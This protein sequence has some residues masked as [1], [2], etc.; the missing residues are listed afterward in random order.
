MEIFALD[1]G[2]KQT[3]L[4]SKKAEYVLPSQILN[5]DDMS[6]QL[7]SFGK[8]R[9]I[10][11]FKVPFDDSTWLWGSDLVT[12][13]RDDYLQD[14]LMHQNRYTNDTFKLLANFALGLLA[15]DYK[16]AGEGILEVT[17]VTGLPTDDYNSSKQLADLTEVL[18]GQHQIEVN[19]KTYTVRVERV[20]IVPQPVGTFYDVLLDKKGYLQDED[21]LEEKVGIVDA[22]GGTI[23]I[24]T[25]LNFELDKRNRR[26]YSTGANDLYEA[27]MSQMD[28]NV[29]LYQIE[30]M[31]RNGIKERHFSYRYSKNHIEDVTDLVEKEITNFTRRLVSNLKSTFKDVDSID[32]LIITGGSANLINQR[33]ISDTFEG[34]T[35]VKNSE[36]ANV[37]GFYKYALTKEGAEESEEETNTTEAN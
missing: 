3:K 36:F 30:K 16:K 23:L 17:V 14:T 29:S 25:L 27:I 10:N 12:L 37:R 6:Q 7:S 20:L 8:K 15:T 9:D 26:Q 1:L 19:G 24:D 35:F 32:T 18:K 13:K 28:G 31:V 34:V 33:L 22:G 2:N 21:L 4:K 5:Q 11:Y